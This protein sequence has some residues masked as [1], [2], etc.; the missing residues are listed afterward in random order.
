[1]AVDTPP[2]L[3]I[4]VELSVLSILKELVLFLLPIALI[5][6]PVR[7]IKVT[8]GTL[9]W[10]I[11]ISNEDE[12]TALTDPVSR[13]TLLQAL[14]TKLAYLYELEGPPLSD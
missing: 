3:V 9:F 14:L 6:A 1:M 2:T 12:A 10:S 8:C 4:S 5:I 7:S 11:W 13:F